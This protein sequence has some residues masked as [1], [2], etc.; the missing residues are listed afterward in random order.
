MKKLL[1][2][3]IF[4][5]TL[6]IGYAQLGNDKCSLPGDVGLFLD[7]TE[8]LPR[9]LSSNVEQIS[10]YVAPRIVNGVKMID[11]FIAVDNNGVVDALR[12]EG[13]MINCEFD[14]FVTARIPVSSLERISL[15]N[16][17]KDVSISR[18]LDL[19][20][21]S[22][23][24][25]THAGQVINGFQN[26]LPQDYDGS[27]VIV[28]IIDC[29]FDYQHSA[30]K[31]TS[32]PTKTRIVRIYDPEKT[33]GH[34]VTLEGNT[35]PGSVFM[36]EEIDTLRYDVTST[37]GTHTASIAAGRHVN[38]YGGMAPG[39]DI[40]LCVSRT[41]N[42]GISET[43]VINCIKYI[44]S[45][46]D[47]VGKPC[48]ISVSVSTSGG[49]HDGKDYLSKAI[50]QLV[51]PGRIFVV[52]AGNNA[53]Q[54]YYVGEQASKAVPAHFLVDCNSSSTTDNNYYYNNVYFESWVRTLQT[55]PVLRFHILD[56]RT[57]KIV[58][59][60]DSVILG[61]MFTHNAVSDYFEPDLS[62]GN[63]G[64]MYASVS[65]GGNSS[66]FKVSSKV[67]NLKSKSYYID[68]TT[69]I[70]MSNYRIGFSISPYSID[71]FYVDNWM[72]TSVGRFGEMTSPVY[73][74]SIGPEG[75]T[76]TTSVSQFY[77]IPDNSCSIGSYAVCDSVISAGAYA[78]RNSY[79]SMLWNDTIYDSWISV[80]N[81]YSASSYEAPGC[82]PTGKA[83]PTITAPGYHVVAAGSQYSYMNSDY[84][85][86]LVM[87]DDEGS[88]WG[89]MTGTSMAAPTVAGIIAQW[90]QLYPNLTTS[91]I[92]EVIA[93][94]AIKDQFT[95]ATY[96]FG[97]NGKI[98]ALAGIIYLIKND[99]SFM[100][101]D[102]NGDG[103]VSVL[104]VS[105]MIDQLLGGNVPGFN[106][107]VADITQDGRF[108][109]RDVVILI[110]ML[111]ENSGG[112]EDD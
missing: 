108:S 7:E 33:T 97:P 6:S 40:V 94:T 56:K 81:I 44:Y 82:G 59:E 109:V 100:L 49:S 54:P 86:E 11:A 2:A 45:Y 3:V 35:L 50:K 62:V 8:N 70:K 84:R 48:V 65:L 12:K 104:D 71:S 18:A 93:Q 58:W 29:G 47:S 96:Q 24:S 9:M 91:Q 88:V 89:V 37:H 4:L 27:G 102:V 112:G 31:S 53:A 26:G 17:V 79:F 67:M 34:V 36:G 13:V 16:G 61:T 39:A 32:D 20:T 19:C 95:N 111:L 55:R 63:M 10:S 69:G 5:L 41:L 1:I 21:D 38:G 52:A 51:G 46:A 22:T 23:L 85:G 106:P 80:G 101:G 98:D 83:L 57:N 90:L 66:K 64:Y 75:D 60:S 76:V 14:G 42:T 68:A 92:K 77:A 87:R 103:M 28:G 73:I 99:P 25:V 72:G 105:L 74:E 107:I 15:L 110:D 78:A 43:E 30:F